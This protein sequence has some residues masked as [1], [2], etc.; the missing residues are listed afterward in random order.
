MVLCWS[1]S[2][3]L[4]MHTSRY[5]WWG[6]GSVFQSARHQKYSLCN[7]L[8]NLL[9]PSSWE[10]STL[11]AK[12]GIFVHFLVKVRRMNFLYSLNCSLLFHLN[13]QKN[14]F[15]ILQNC[16]FWNFNKITKRRNFPLLENFLVYTDFSWRLYPRQCVIIIPCILGCQA[17]LRPLF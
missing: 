11:N 9:I 16:F 12:L 2:E 4:V 5:C 17:L 15:Y 14:N 3:T 8:S 7:K 13:Y 6:S 10:Y 1:V